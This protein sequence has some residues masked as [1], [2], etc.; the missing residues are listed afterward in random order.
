MVCGSEELVSR[1]IRVEVRDTAKFRFPVTVAV[2]F[3]ARY[4]GNYRDVAVKIVDGVRRVSYITPV[5]TEGT[6][7]GQRVNVSDTLQFGCT[8]FLLKISRNS[9][10]EDVMVCVANPLAPSCAS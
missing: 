8:M 10:C 2:P 6:Y 9:E 5:T 1:V 7:G 4:R 3:C